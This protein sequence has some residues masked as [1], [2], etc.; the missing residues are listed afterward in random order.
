ME[1]SQQAG[2]LAY[3]EEFEIELKQKVPPNVGKDLT[4]MQNPMVS[5]V[6]ARDDSRDSVED[7]KVHTYGGKEVPVCTM[8]K[9]DEAKSNDDGKDVKNCYV[10]KKFGILYYTEISEDSP[11]RIPT[12][13]PVLSQPAKKFRMLQQSLHQKESRPLSGI[14]S[15]AMSTLQKKRTPLMIHQFMVR[16]TSKLTKPEMSIQP[17][18]IHQFHSLH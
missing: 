15:I 12:Q 8:N 11:E 10:H 9:I 4:D 5:I 1:D 2:K 18:K 16:I 7:P 14:C 13:P 17:L 3:E 6:T